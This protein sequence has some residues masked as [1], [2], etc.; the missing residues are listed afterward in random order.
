[1]RIGNKGSLV[2]KAL[3][4]SLLSVFTP[5]MSLD[6]YTIYMFFLSFGSLDLAETFAMPF[7][8]DNIILAY[9]MISFHYLIVYNLDS[10]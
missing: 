2:A 3:I 9:F 6:F 4:H 5:A 7:C 8:K 10:C 1:M